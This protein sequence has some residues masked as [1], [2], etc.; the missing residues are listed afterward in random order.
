VTFAQRLV[1][2]HV[3]GDPP[4]YE[5]GAIQ[6]AF[7]PQDGIGGSSSVRGLPKN[8][9]VGRGLALSNSEVRWR[10]TDFSLRGRESSV[11]LSAFTDVGRVWDKG[12]DMSTALKGLHSGY[13]LGARFAFGSSFVVAADVGHSAQSTAPIYIGLGYL[14]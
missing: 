9:Y 1:L 4:F 12:V 6:T 7:K 14:F 11:V 5:L 13:G 2:Q 10:A 3:A 8:R